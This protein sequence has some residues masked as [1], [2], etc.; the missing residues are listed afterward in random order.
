MCVIVIICLCFQPGGRRTAAK[1][2][3]AAI[4][5]AETAMASGK[6]IDW[7][8]QVALVSKNFTFLVCVCFT[9]GC[10]CSKIIMVSVFLLNSNYNKRYY[11]KRFHV[12]TESCPD[13]EDHLYGPE[14]PRALPP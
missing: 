10:E 7:L 6:E 12:P 9:L 5:M 13:P 3:A 1:N 4:E 14:D 8:G 11:Q 2:K